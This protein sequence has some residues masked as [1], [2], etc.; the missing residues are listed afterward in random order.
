[1]KFTLYHGFAISLA[2]HAAIG[3]PFAMYSLASPPDEPPTIVI[4]LQGVIANVQADQK[5]L[6]QIKG[7]LEQETVEEQIETNETTVSMPPPP[8]DAVEPK[9]GID[10]NDV[11]GVEQ[12]QEARTIRTKQ[13]QR[14]RFA[15]YV[16]LLSKK[17]RANLVHPKSG[18]RASA[19]VSFTILSSGQIRLD[20]LKIVQSSGQPALDASALQTIRA[21]APFDPPPEEA[22]VTISVD[23][24]RTP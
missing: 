9:P 5:V 19:F 23:F 14:D 22:T 17:V 12:R 4:D 2:L 13:E 11:A 3:A 24:D 20:T 16:K 18:R 7:A 10:L 8:D 21:S 1:M 6:E 15:E